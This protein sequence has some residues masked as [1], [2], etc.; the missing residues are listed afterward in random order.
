MPMAAPDDAGRIRLS[1]LLI[2]GT[3]VHMPKAVRMQALN[4]IKS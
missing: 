2:Q 4:S 1:G 3:N